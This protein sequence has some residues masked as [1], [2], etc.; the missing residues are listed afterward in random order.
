MGN[1]AKA[2]A[3]AVAF[4]PQMSRASELNEVSAS[5]DIP[6]NYHNEIAGKALPFPYQDRFWRWGVAA[7]QGGG[8]FNPLFSFTCNYKG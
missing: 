7:T 2:G 1:E 5:L 4:A 8:G 6:F 3:G